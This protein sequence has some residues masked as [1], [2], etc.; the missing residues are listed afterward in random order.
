MRMSAEDIDYSNAGIEHLT[1][2]YNG[3]DMEIGFN[4]KFLIE[5]LQNMDS[6]QIQ[7]EMSDPGRAGI[8]VPHDGEDED[9][10]ILM[11]VM[12]IMLGQ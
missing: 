12:P 10:D 1:V 9:E 7:I 3:E 11:L 6:E 2:N 8:I 4:S 5:M